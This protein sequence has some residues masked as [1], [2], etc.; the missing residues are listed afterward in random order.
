[1][2][3][4]GCELMSP[5]IDNDVV[6]DT[7]AAGLAALDGDFDGFN[8][9]MNNTDTEMLACAALSLLVTALRQSGCDPRACLTEGLAAFQ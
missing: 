4:G 6:R 8:A 3:S 2:P 9:I 5:E 7:F 1:M